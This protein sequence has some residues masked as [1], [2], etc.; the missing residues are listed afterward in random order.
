MPL[1]SGV[2]SH[3]LRHLSTKLLF[4]HPPFS[5]AVKPYKLFYI[6]FS[7][8]GHG[9]GLTRWR[10]VS[11]FFCDR[12]CPLISIQFIPVAP[13]KNKGHW[14]LERGDFAP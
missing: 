7:F 10:C 1:L 6:F 13:G 12:G 4:D 3:E 9:G 8:F 11:S 14:E 2:L 5:D